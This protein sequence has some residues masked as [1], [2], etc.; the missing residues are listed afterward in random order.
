[1]LSKD[2]TDA[3]ACEPVQIGTAQANRGHAQQNIAGTG[4]RHWFVM[5]THI[6]WLMQTKSFHVV[7][8]FPPTGEPLAIDTRMRSDRVWI[9]GK[10]IGTA[11]SRHSTFSDMSRVPC[12]TV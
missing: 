8:V 12:R 11:S 5:E 7:S 3:S 10:I 2:V 1:M 4:H 6:S 9:V